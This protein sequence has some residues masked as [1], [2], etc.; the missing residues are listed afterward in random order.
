MQTLL[1]NW[2]FFRILRAALGVFI[3]VQ[4][5]V[6]RDTFSIIIG[7]VFAGLAIFNIGCCGAGGCNTTTNKKSTKSSFENIE[8]EEVIDEK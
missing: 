6:T 4:G 2:N 8:Y 7:I 1:S 5:V 3:L